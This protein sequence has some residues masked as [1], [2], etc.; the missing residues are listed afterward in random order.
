MTSARCDGLN[1]FETQGRIERKLDKCGAAT[2][3]KKEHGGS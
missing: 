1:I 3:E 2:G